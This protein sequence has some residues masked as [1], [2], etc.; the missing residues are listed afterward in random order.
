MNPPKSRNQTRLA[1]VKPADEDPQA[2]ALFEGVGAGEAD[3][4]ER[5]GQA[6]EAASGDLGFGEGR[7]RRRNRE[8]RGI[9]GP[10]LGDQLSVQAGQSRDPV[11]ANDP[12]GRVE[13]DGRPQDPC[14]HRRAQAPRKKAADIAAIARIGRSA[15]LRGDDDLCDE[16][17]CGDVEGQAAAARGGGASLSRATSASYCDHSSAGRR[18]PNLS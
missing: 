14:D 10:G 17:G 13:G 6:D 12:Q 4:M 1:G 8:I 2:V 5:P 3:R 7:R 15:E 11:P 9:A 18:S 16:V